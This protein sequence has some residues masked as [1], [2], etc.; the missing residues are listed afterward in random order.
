M[1]IGGDTL[2]GRVGEGSARCRPAPRIAVRTV[3]RGPR[4]R[5]GA[6]AGGFDEAT[7]G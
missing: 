6:P 2:R 5:D 4:A 7:G 1:G 3:R